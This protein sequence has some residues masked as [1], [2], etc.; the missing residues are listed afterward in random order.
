MDF[1]KNCRF[2]GERDVLV[3]SELPKDVQEELK[4]VEIYFLV[5][6]EITVQSPLEPTKCVCHPLEEKHLSRCGE[7]Q[8]FWSQ[9]PLFK[10]FLS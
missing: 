10:E 9:H 3:K 4:D 5:A 8:I 7:C 1:R 6:D 2:M